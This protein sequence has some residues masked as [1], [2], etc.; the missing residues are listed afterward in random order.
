MSKRILLVDGHSIANR[1]FFGVPLLTNSKG[2][3]TNALFGFFNILFS[4]IDRV[5]PDQL[6]IAF[7]QHH[8]TFRHE[9][10][11]EYKGNR[12]AMQPEL[13]EQ[14]PVLQ[15]MLKKAG[16]QLL[17]RETLEADDLLGTAAKKAGKEGCEVTL[18]SGDR[19]LLQLVDEQITMLLPKTKR[20][21]TEYEVYH[22][23]DVVEKYGVEPAGYLQ[24]KGL[25]GDSSDNIPG[26][27]KIGEKTAS[28]II[29]TYGTIEEAI[30]HVD[31]VK[32]P[33]ASRNL[34]EYRE[35][36]R[37]SLVLSTIVTDA[38]D[39]P[40]PCDLTEM[41]FHTPEFVEDVKKYELKSLLKRLLQSAPMQTPKTSKTEGTAFET[42]DEDVP[43]EFMED[44][45]DSVESVSESG[46]VTGE[47]L[48]SAGELSE[49]LKEYLEKEPVLPIFTVGDEAGD[50]CGAAVGPYYVDTTMDE[51]ISSI[52]PYLENASVKKIFCD[53]KPIY[54][55]VLSAGKEIHGPM[56]DTMIQAYLLNATVGHYT[57]DT[58][59]L[60]YLDRNIPSEEEMVGTGAK[61]IS[62]R[63]TDDKERSR[64]V[65]NVAKVLKEA[66]PVMEKKLE[67]SGMKDLY[68]QVEGPLVEVLASMENEGIRVDLNE[69]EDFGSLLK[70]DISELQK[71][72]Y[73]LAG[74]EFNI[75]STK[76]L[77]QILFEKMGLPAG[78]KTKSGYSTSAEVL[79][80]LKLYHP[81]I[82]RILEYRQLTKLESTYVEGMK[83]YVGKGGKIRCSFQQAVTATGRLSCTEPNLQ[84][85]PIREKRG[86]E[87]RK[88]FVPTD[89]DHFFM[90]ADYSQIELR[91]L[92]H[93]SG[94]ATMIEAYNK[95]ADIHRLT[96]SQVL[97]IP[98]E[99]ITPSQRSSAKAVNFGI[100]YGMSAFSLAGDL[101]LTNKEAAQYIED[102]YAQFPGVK[103]FLTSC[104]D[105]A[106]E[107]GYGVTLFGR[108]RNIEELKAKN[109]ALRSFGER[110]A[111]NMPIQGT[112]ADIIKIAMV[113]VYKRLKKEGMK[114]KLILQVHD[115]L[116][117]EVLRSEEEKVRSI[118]IEEMQGACELSVP[119]TVDVE[120]GENWYEAK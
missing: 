113:K 101:G 28:K 3:Y 30:A 14:I 31:E 59:A 56:V 57:P 41:V 102:Y 76:Q 109:F 94:D 89:C 44:M 93:M 12:S 18:L 34:S 27:P 69:L 38:E 99:E 37:M 53:A 116:M 81:I 16:V 32:P 1:A 83:P 108:R 40:E 106:K 114:S 97:H 36:A 72:I 49:R 107:D 39:V 62:W 84:N 33:M 52:A 58:I 71:E 2:Q 5:K 23:Q 86:R 35:Q 104:V 91:L 7:D 9:M 46:D 4:A 10:Y 17:M 70:E 77:G 8:P 98:Y 22:V 42:V 11:A 64:Y 85:I 26:V 21:G 25:M 55:A 45:A 24:M 19:D 90:D 78:K 15:E 47:V 100:I 73:D 20:E 6:A 63:M 118:L 117:I 105:K 29:Q 54:K 43:E 79:E 51:L 67:E 80:G 92:A 74:E 115:E 110:V 60:A 65:L 120:T 82:G 66:A 61:K 13:K 50:I 48:E 87:L 68:E 112:A 75:N 88:A 103:G 111:K 119:L 96:A 95:G